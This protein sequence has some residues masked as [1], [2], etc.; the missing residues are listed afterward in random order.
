MEGGLGR[1]SD[2]V[3]L[4]G[5]RT[6]VS[7]VRRVRDFKTTDISPKGLLG[8]LIR[9]VAFTLKIQLPHQTR[10]PVQC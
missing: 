4:G 9:T 1:P 8:P 6:G 5:S 2:H 7:P 3:G 10:E